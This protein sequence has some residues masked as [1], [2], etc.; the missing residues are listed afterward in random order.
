MSNPKHEAPWKKVPWP[1]AD[2]YPDCWRRKIKGGWC[3]LCETEHFTYT[4]S[5]GNASDW[6][7]TGGFYGHPEIQTIDDAKAAI[8]ALA[9]KYNG[10]LSQ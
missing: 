4:S 6:S 10:R 5:C 9:E 8:D 1:F 3:Y 7:F 2:G